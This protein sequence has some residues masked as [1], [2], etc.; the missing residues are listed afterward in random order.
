MTSSGC[1]EV[2]VLKF[3]GTSVATP[4]RIR[5]AALRVRAQL[6][7]GYSVAVVVSA[8]G[9][10]TDHLLA[11]IGAVAGA[12]AAGSSDPA[13][14]REVD[15]VLATGEDRSAGVLALALQA[16]GIPALSMR[17]GEAGIMAVGDFGAGVIE[18]VHTANV[19]RL[20]A[21]GVVPVV[22]GFQGERLDGETVTLGRGGSDTSAVALAAALG[23]KEC[24]IVTDV[25]AV[26][27]RDPRLY[28]DAKPYETL[29]FAELIALTEAG[30]QVVHPR[31][32]RLA[33]THQLPLRVYDFR[34]PW[35]GG[36]T[37]ITATAPA[38]A[39]AATAP[40]RSDVPLVME[41]A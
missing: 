26:Y 33:A 23:A 32:A 27:D 21:R 41:V 13:V 37:L 9:H 10:E 1:D 40:E 28:P 20:M 24:H 18:R 39:E 31:A 4:K 17:G 29:D 3:G 7:R 8:A 2:L 30:A 6:R 35:S 12:E 16:L 22:S 5:R 14:R 11:R 34:A 36:G 19:R 25:D 15:R 38:H